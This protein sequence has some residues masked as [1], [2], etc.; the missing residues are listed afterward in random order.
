[1]HSNGGRGLIFDVISSAAGESSRAG[2]P[3][4]LGHLRSSGG[5]GLIAGANGG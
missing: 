1:M 5:V 4:A 2:N 3:A